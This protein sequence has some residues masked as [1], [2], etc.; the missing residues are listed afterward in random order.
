MILFGLGQNHAERP[1]ALSKIGMLQ[2]SVHWQCLSFRHYAFHEFGTVEIESEWTATRREA[3]QKQ[4]GG[5]S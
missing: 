1:E 3:E 5:T 2:K 4:A